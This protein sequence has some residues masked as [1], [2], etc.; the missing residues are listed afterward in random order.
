[1]IK[2][3]LKALISEKEFNE[4]RRVTYDEIAKSTGISITT[5]SKIANTKGYDTAVSKIE[6]LCLYF[7]CT[8]EDLITIVQENAE[9]D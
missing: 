6:K 4:G 5:L 9:K 1:M 7:N 8:P 2:Y 3:N